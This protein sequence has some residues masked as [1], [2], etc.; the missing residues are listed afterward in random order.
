MEKYLRELAARLLRLSRS[1]LDI[2][3]GKRLRE[4][5]KEVAEKA[6]EAERSERP[7]LKEQAS[8]RRDH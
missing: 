8:I 2:G 4:F 7:L 3:T 6:A 1:T 5:S